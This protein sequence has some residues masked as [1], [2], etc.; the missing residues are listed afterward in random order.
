MSCL[1]KRNN[2]PYYWWSAYYLGKRFKKS[3]KMSLHRLA[4]KVQAIWDLKLLENDL[5]F[6]GIEKYSNAECMKITDL[7]TDF[8]KLRERKSENACITAKGVTKRFQKYLINKNVVSVQE[9]TLNIL[10]GYVDWLKVSTKTIKNHFIVIRIMLQYAVKSGYIEKNYAKDVTLPTIK[11]NDLH[12]NL[13]DDDLKAIFNNADKWDL[14]YHFLYYTGLRAGD[15]ALLKFSDINRNKKAITT[16]IRKS[17]RTH[18]FPISDILLNLLP[19]ILDDTPIFP[20]LY[21]EDARKVNDKITNPRKHM[22]KSL[23]DAG[24]K[25]ATLHSFRTTFNNRL[26]DLGLQIEDRQI[27][28][29]QSASETTKIYTHPNFELAKQYVNKI[30]E[31]MGL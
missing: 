30:P 20:N 2:S 31:I 16:F 27:L 15:V 13:N 29:A 10:N 22:Q 18:E 24:L 1:Y 28:L 25:K 8:L 23:K 11:H 19:E 26:R 6:L 4:K 17:D 7:V 21:H 5:A 3:T 9:I 12:R 14:Y